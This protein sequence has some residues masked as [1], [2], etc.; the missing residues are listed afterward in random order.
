MEQ[1][2]LFMNEELGNEVRT[3]YEKDGSVCVSV[4]DVARGF[5]FT[6]VKNDKEYV[7]WETVKG[8][9]VEFGYSH[10]VGKDDFI[11]ESMFYMLG[12]KANN[13][14]A[15]KFQ[16]WL[17]TIVIPSIRK[18]GAFL[19]DSENID[20]E[21]VLNE[22]RFSQKRTIK[23]F[24]NAEIGDIKKLY[25]EF[26]DYVDREYKYKTDTRIARYK[27]VEKGLQQLR[28]SIAIDGDSVGDCYNIEKLKREVIIDRTTLEKRVSGGIRAGQT[29]L[30]GELQD[31]LE[32]YREIEE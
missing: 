30:I 17:A 27:S 31:E 25:Q 9:L 12:M 7:R 14:T 15:R 23:T 16:M 4:E 29:R 18:H 2:Q 26:K 28:D 1:V 8:Y 21:F 32:T 24:A 20:E 10:P 13:E 22:L 5:G 6:Q 11:P 19:A 3:K